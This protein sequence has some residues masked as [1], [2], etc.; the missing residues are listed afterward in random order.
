[1]ATLQDLSNKSQAELIEMLLAA[2][3]KAN[4]ER[5]NGIKIFALGTSN[6]DGVPYK[7]TVGVR[8]GKNY[9]VLYASQWLEVLDKADDIRKA[10]ED[11]K[12]ML[13]WKE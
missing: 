13:S 1:M 7:G 11:N 4:G 5:G 6:K 3:A 8:T 12:A 9:T 10:I 2:Q